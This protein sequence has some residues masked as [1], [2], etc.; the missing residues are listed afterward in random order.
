[1]A[2]DCGGEHKDTPPSAVEALEAC[3]PVYEQMPGWTQSTVG[4]KRYEELPENARRYLQRLEE[5][6]DK[7]IDIVSTGPDR[8]ETII[9]RHPFD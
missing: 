6:T 8:N 9:L 7:P 1:M 3:E 5:I 4:V 2:Y